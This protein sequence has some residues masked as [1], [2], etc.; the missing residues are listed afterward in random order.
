MLTETHNPLVPVYLNQRIVFDLIAM[1]QDGIA[2]VTKVFER[3]RSESSASNHLDGSF[4]LNKA[5]SSLLSINLSG[6]R[7]RAK[8]DETDATRDAERVHTPASLFFKL[9]ELLD[10]R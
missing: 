9:R 1:L 10:E 6:K 2:T 5:F 8:T 4:G 3:T 7:G